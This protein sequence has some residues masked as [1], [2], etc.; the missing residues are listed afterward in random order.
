LNGSSLT[1]VLL[2]RSG[3]RGLLGD[4]PE[5]SGERELGVIAG[6]SG[7]GIGSVVGGVAGPGDGTVAMAETTL[8]GATDHCLISTGHMGMVISPVVAM[9]VSTFLKTGQFSGR[10]GAF[11]VKKG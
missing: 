2:G 6:Y 10:H 7:F 3:E 9:E 4:A 5:W 1:R 11:D 8:P